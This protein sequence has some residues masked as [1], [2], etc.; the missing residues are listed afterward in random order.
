MH[1]YSTTYTVHTHPCIPAKNLFL[2]FSISLLYVRHHW[3]NIWF[4]SVELD[5]SG[6]LWCQY[7]DQLGRRFSLYTALS[8][9]Q[10]PQP[11][12]VNT[13]TDLQTNW[14]GADKHVGPS[15]LYSK[16]HEGHY[17]VNAPIDSSAAKSY[18][19]HCRYHREGR[20]IA[21]RDTSVCVIQ[22]RHL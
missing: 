5:G 1:Y 22:D 8:W 13:P 12:L 11:T 17:H 20:L 14:A 3:I 18:S 15:R 16:W 21:G 7:R 19:K 2:S 4:Q 6:A 9:P 10:I